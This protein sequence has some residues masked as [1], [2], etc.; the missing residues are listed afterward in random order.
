VSFIS[1]AIPET[2][3][4]CAADS[5][6]EALG[7]RRKCRR[8]VLPASRPPWEEYDLIISSRDYND[9]CLAVALPLKAVAENSDDTGQDI[10]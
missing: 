3:G 5:G 4:C 1:V 7:D 9:F 6:A 10:C 2:G 8:V